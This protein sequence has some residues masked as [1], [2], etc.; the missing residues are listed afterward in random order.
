M[1]KDLSVNLDAL[2]QSVDTFNIVAH[3][4]LKKTL[5][6]SELVAQRFKKFKKQYKKDGNKDGLRQAVYREHEQHE[7]L[8]FK[9]S[10]KHR[11]VGCYTLTTSFLQTYLQEKF[12]IN[13]KSPEELFQQ[14][15]DLTI[16]THQEAQNLIALSK[17]P[18]LFSFSSEPEI[19]VDV[20]QYGICMNDILKRLND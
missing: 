17:D 20:I 7:L 16:I 19:P 8:I 15:L 18:Q 13:A 1:H 2:Q 11:F 12:S 5:Q 10:V 3:E 9:D 14:C 6:L 4:F